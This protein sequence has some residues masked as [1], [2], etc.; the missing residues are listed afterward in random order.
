MLNL[1]SIA[2]GTIP[3]G[4]KGLPP[5]AA[6]RP[7]RDLGLRGYNLLAGDIPL[8]A[9]V[10]SREAMSHN[11]AV[12]REFTQRMGVLLAPHGKSTMA[13]QLFAEQLD[14]GAWA[15]TAA[16]PA[17]LFAYR[18]VNVPANSVCQS[19]HRSHRNRLRA[20]RARARSC[21][22]VHLPGGQRCRS[23]YSG[24]CHARASHH[25]A[26]RRPDRVRNCRRAGRAS[27]GRTRRCFLRDTLP[28]RAH[29]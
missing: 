20:R 18:S 27:A 15:M 6:G 3:A 22:R 21:V 14:D 1:E 12:M 17:H 29:S 19:A 7:Q 26:S 10:L 16:T 23:Q 13:P 28:R 11:R 24:G 9:C 25:P 2:G 5:A 4:T 8:P